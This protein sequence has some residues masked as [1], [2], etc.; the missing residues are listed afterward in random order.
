MTV[1]SK[2]VVIPINQYSRVVND[3][4]KNMMHS[5]QTIPSE[6]TNIVMSGIYYLAFY[7]RMYVE[8]VLWERMEVSYM[9]DMIWADLTNYLT[10]QYMTTLE[11]ATVFR[12]DDTKTHEVIVPLIE[13]DKY[14]RWGRHMNEY[15]YRDTITPT[16]NHNPRV[17][18]IM[19][20]IPQ[21]IN[22]IDYNGMSQMVDLLV[23]NT[24]AMYAEYDL[25]AFP[26]YIDIVDDLADKIDK[27]NCDVRNVIGVHLHQTQRTMYL[28]LKNASISPLT[29]RI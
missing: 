26:L 9:H 5:I 21:S 17:E 3:L 12:E 13:S 29:S 27:L 18:Y 7:D 20:E 1:P 2:Y 15:K 10:E 24:I 22:Y 19:S 6:F 4:A 11:T 16:V 14:H 23:E 8:D 28:Q 25:K